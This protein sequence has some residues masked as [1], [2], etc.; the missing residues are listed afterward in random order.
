MGREAVRYGEGGGQIWGGRWS[1]MGREAVR[2]REGGG[3]I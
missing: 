2:Y 3:Q 1:D